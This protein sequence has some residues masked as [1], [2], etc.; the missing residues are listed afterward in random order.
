MGELKGENGEQEEKRRIK[1]MREQ[2]WVRKVWRGTWSKVCPLLP[3]PCVHTCNTVL[4]DDVHLPLLNASRA[5]PVLHALRIRPRMLGS[6]CCDRYLRR[7]VR[8]RMIVMC[9]VLL[10]VHVGLNGRV[11]SSGS[12]PDRE[13][14]GWLGGSGTVRVVGW[15][16]ALGTY[17]RERKRERGRANR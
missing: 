12:N 17:G 14:G 16:A 10:S 13:G 3:P 2:R 8:G 7:V 11:V 6:R 15:S 1:K 5:F 4:H 9:V